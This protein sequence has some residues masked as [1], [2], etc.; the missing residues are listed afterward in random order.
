M[1][2]L[3]LCLFVTLLAAVGHASAAEDVPWSQNYV[4]L[5]GQEHTQLLNQGKEIQ[6]SMDQSSGSGFRSLKTYGS[7]FFGMRMKLPNKDTT[8]I[9]TSFYLRSHTPKHDELD[10]EFLG[11]KTQQYLLQTNVFTNGQ[12]FREQ[13]ISL[14]FDPTTDFHNYQIL[15][16][17][18][19]VVW[20][21]DDT[22]IRVFKNNN[23][24]GVGYPAQSMQIEA[25]IWNGSWAGEPNWSQAP[26]Q[27]YYQGFGID[28]CLAQNHTIGFSE[29]SSPTFSWNGVK[30]WK[31]DSQQQSAY[32]D[33]R[34]KYLVY[35][36]CLAGSKPPPECPS[37]Q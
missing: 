3:V 36:Y 27:A 2:S 1:D 19:Q 11:G 10:F 37:N 18:H 16:N 5:Y 23:K 35:D 29:C 32:E 26:F 30:Y 31:L 6:I 4:I 33:V 8:G 34:N 9:I 25:T 20:F 24:I 13:R 7:G 12:G 14:W 17:Q 28:G 22:P 15:W 21:V